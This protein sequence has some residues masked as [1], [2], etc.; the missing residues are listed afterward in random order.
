VAHVAHALP[1]VIKAGVSPRFY[2]QCAAAYAGL[3]L[4]A[5]VLTRTELQLPLV[6]FRTQRAEKVVLSTTAVAMPM[7]SICTPLQTA[8]LLQTADGESCYSPPWHEASNA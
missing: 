5:V 3:T 1:V 4:A 7:C 6:H 8:V 2:A